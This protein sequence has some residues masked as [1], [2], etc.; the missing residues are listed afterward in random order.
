MS[1]CDGSSNPIPSI[2]GRAV[3]KVAY[4]GDASG[5]GTLS[6][7][8]AAL[9]ARNSVMIDD[10]FSASPLTD[11]RIIGDVTGNGTL[12]AMDAMYVSQAAVQIPQSLIPA[13]PVHTTITHA[14][15]DPTVAVG[16][17]VLA[18]PGQTVDVPV[19]IT[20]D[21]NGVLAAGLTITY[22]SNVLSLTNPT[23][24]EVKLSSY[25]N[26]LGW[27]ISSN[28]TAPGTLLVSIFSMGGALP[29]GAAQLLDL[30]FQVL[31]TAT[32]GTSQI[33]L[34]GQLNEGQLV[35]TPVN[36]SVNVD[37]PPQVAAVYVGSTSWAS[38]FT[39][40]LATSGLGGQYGYAIPAGAS[41][42]APLP[43]SNI[44]QIAI[45]FTKDV[46]V[47]QA[48]LILNG[49]AVSTYTY[50]T[51]NGFS[52]DPTTHTA[53]WTLA[54]PIASDKLLIAL[55]GAAS[56][57]ITDAAGSRLTGS[58]TDGTSAFPSG[59]GTPG[60]NFF[61]HFNVLPGDVKQGAAVTSTSLT[62]ERND[63]GTSTADPTFG[64][65]SYSIF[66]DLNANGSIT[67]SD[68]TIERND[69]GTFLPTGAAP[70]GSGDFADWMETNSDWLFDDDTV[71][72]L[73][74]SAATTDSVFSSDD[75]NPDLL[76]ADDLAAAMQVA[77]AGDAPDMGAAAEG[78]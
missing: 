66:A 37:A 53:I 32:L 21:A 33:G 67:S 4:F 30:N 7:Y 45:T 55:N 69:Q 75:F 8:D 57:A 60:T 34:S 43:W 64:V 28:V 70:S 46:T 11:P 74:S 9:I 51:T 42:A 27:G 49:T 56:G 52:Y 71:S 16:S 12:S 3:E 39:S 1:W 5:D 24:A 73:A 6:G 17:S 14:S 72:Q 54:N 76:A 20:D 31:A 59:N 35:M 65:N 18:N 29:S 19:S 50:A 63:Q 68:L 47:A 58:W 61:F 15:V 22:D 62:V 36:G 23:N 38:S 44:N 77:G 25:L 10:G 26:G 40:Y 41:Q 78:V 48:D 13:V 2:G